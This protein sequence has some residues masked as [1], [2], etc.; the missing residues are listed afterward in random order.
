MNIVLTICAIFATLA[1]VA[2]AQELNKAR[3]ALEDIAQELDYI[4]T[5]KN[6]LKAE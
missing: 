2:I 4:E 3:E 5:N 1:L 6:E